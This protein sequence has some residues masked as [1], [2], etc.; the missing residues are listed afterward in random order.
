MQREWEPQPE[1]DAYF[2]QGGR[3]YKFEELPLWAIRIRKQAE[4]EFPGRAIV[5]KAKSV[6]AAAEVPDAS[7][8]F[9]FIDADHVEESVRADILAWRPKIRS[10][11]VLAGHDINNCSG[12]RAA[13]DSLCPGWQ[14]YKQEVWGIVLP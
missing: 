2:S 4:R 5:I 14:A 11:G 7:L 3:S 6:D 10:G 9:V 12:V 8:D 13:V 1:K